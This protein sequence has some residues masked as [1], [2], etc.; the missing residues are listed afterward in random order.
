MKKSIR[1][2]LIIKK[3]IL[4]LLAFAAA[5]MLVL[6]VYLNE[7][8]I[9]Y[10]SIYVCAEM[11]IIFVFSAGENYNYT[12]KGSMVLGNTRKHIYSS[13]YVFN[14]I[15]AVLLFILQFIIVNFGGGKFS[16]LYVLIFLNISFMGCFLGIAYL[17]DKKLSRIIF[18]VSYLIFT[19]VCCFML[20]YRNHVT[21]IEILYGGLVLTSILGATAVIWGWNIIKSCDLK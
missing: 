17:Y 2:R 12:I 10:Y 15:V 21:I 6:A 5:V 4:I 14:G 19:I 13:I 11:I 1:E 7:K 9:N 16:V 3:K 8:K 18:T 20:V